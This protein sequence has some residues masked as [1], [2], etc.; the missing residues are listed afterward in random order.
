MATMLAMQAEAPD[1]PLTMA[2][3]PVP[4]PGSGEARIRVSACGVNFADTLMV[5]GR[6]QER[7]DYPVVPGL[8]V[9]GEVVELGPD[10]NGPP[11]GTRVAA[12][13]GHG[14]YAGEVCA[15]AAACV[16]VPDGMPSDQAASLLV[17]YGTAE[18][19]LR[20][21]ARI[22]PGETLLVLGA[23]GGVGLT[24]VEVGKL[25]GARVIACART[26][27]RLR[28]A[29]ARGADV[30]L[31]VEADALRDAVREV[32]DGRGADVVFDPVGGDMFRAAM[33]AAA[34]EGRLLPIGFASGSVPQIPANILLVK[35]L[36]AIGLYWGI[37]F[38]HKPEVLGE[39]VKRILSWYESG[40]IRPHVGHSLPLRQAEDALE[41]LRN[42][43][44]TG[45]I[46]LRCGTA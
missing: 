29:R 16:P 17:S 24:A 13:C 12:L 8:E 44:S 32:T 33:R 38:R 5:A 9:A 14:G 19:A 41:L 4:A 37:Y 28:H 25:L 2:E 42:R 7:P 15:P 31:A 10:T 34:F 1:A 27:E 18:L 11:P 6:Y 26:E 21:R 43:R 3:R 36:T 30:T 40:S 22:Q 46:V 20:Y 23:A 45:K 39:S 35:N